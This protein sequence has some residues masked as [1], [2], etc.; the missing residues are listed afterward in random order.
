[1]CAARTC[2]E[3]A[4]TLLELHGVDTVFGIPGV[5]TLDLYRGIGNSNLRHIGVRHEQGAGFMADGY[6]RASGRPGVCVLITGPGVTNAATPIGQAYSD[7][8]PVLLLSSVNETENLGKGRGRLHEIT[9]QHAVM[10]PLTGLSRTVRAP[11]ELPGAI[12]AAFEMFAT[13]RP[14]PA[15]IEIPL[16]VLAAPAPTEG[17]KPVRTDRPV[18]DEKSLISAAAI[19]D[20]AKA[21]FLI[22]GG[23]TVDCAPAVIA[24]AERIDA[25]VAVSIAAKGVVPDNHPNCLGSTLVQAATQRA[26][27]EADVVIAVGTELAETD[28]WIERLPINGKL[29]RIDIDAPSLTR[30]YPPAAT[31]LGDAGRSLEAISA[32]VGRKQTSN[33]RASARDQIRDVNAAERPPLQ[34]KHTQILNAVRKAVPEDGTFVT[35]MTQIAYTANYHFPMSQPRRWFH[36]TGYGTLGYALPAAIGAKLATPDRPTVAIAG[37]AGFL[38]TVQELATAVELKMPLAILLWNNDALGQIADDMVRLGIP[39]IGV[40]PRNPDYLAL[41]RAFGAEATRAESADALSEALAA[42]AGAGGP[43]LIE[44]RQDAAWLS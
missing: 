20:S 12:A 38:F 24:L 33:S 4:I 15:H 35:D 25:D 31:V 30:D 23:G 7:S 11:E 13:R 6:A 9:D 32:L 10:A 26:L 28:S 17:A 42:A 19:I 1:M 27:A 37:D 39:E 34:A 5:H 2:G 22:V 3:A 8:V 18:A 21:P 36:P 43:T 41:A 40:K 16:D 14:R 44:V 29:V